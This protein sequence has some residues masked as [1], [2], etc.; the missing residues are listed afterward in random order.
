MMA[1]AEEVFGGIALHFQWLNTHRCDELWAWQGKGTDIM[2][3]LMG[4]CESV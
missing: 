4:W 3:K 2:V 1:P